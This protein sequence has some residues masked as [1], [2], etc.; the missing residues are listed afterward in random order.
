MAPEEK[1]ELIEKVDAALNTIRPHLQADGGNIE[2]VDIT[3]DL[4]VHIKW[5]GNCSACSMSALTMRT[6]IEETL[7]AKVPEVA[8][9]IA[10][11]GVDVV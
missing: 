7:K 10:V 1:K 4:Q 5:L 8:G 11:N 9:V 6:G 2:I 3:N